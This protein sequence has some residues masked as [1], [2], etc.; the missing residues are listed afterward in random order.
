MTVIRGGADQVTEII[1]TEQDTYIT[2]L[3]PGF[4]LPLAQLLAVADA[5]EAA[6]R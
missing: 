5:V 3:L 2:P 4:E 1:I 6:E